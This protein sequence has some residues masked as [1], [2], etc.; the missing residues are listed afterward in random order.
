[1]SKNKKKKTSTKELVKAIKGL[2]NA[3]LI[4]QSLILKLDQD[5]RESHGCCLETYSDD[6]RITLDD[7]YDRIND[8]ADKVCDIY[9]IMGENDDEVSVDKEVE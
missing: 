5:I 6:D 7:I 1:M 2:T 4:Q 8:L 9:C 3:V